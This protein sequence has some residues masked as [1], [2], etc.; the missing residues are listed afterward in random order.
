MKFL[1]QN[2]KFIYLLLIAF[3]FNYIK[4][5]V[6]TN[7]LTNVICPSKAVDGSAPGF[8]TISNITLS[9]TQTNN[10]RKSKTG[11]IILSS[12]TGWFFNTAAVPTLSYPAT[13]DIISMTIAMTNSTTITISFQTFTNTPV[14]VNVFTFSGIQVQAS[15]MLS[16]SGSIYCSAQTGFNPI[17]LVAGVPGTGASFAILSQYPYSQAGVNQIICGNSTTMA[18][19]NP[20]PGTGLWTLLGGT[21]TISTPS[22]NTSAITGIAVGTATLQ[23][24]DSN[25][26]GTTSQVVIT[27]TTIPTSAAGPDQSTCYPNTITMAANFPPYGSGTW[28]ILAGST[29]TSTSQLSSV[30]DESAIFTPTGVGTYTLQWTISLAGCT[31]STDN[32]VVTVTAG[33]NLSVAG[34]S[35]TVCLGSTATMAANTATT[36]ATATW[37]VI[38]GPSVLLSQFSSAISPTAVFTPAGGAGIYILSWAISKVGCTST[39]NMT[40]TVNSPPTVAAAGADQSV[41]I[42]GTLTANTPAVGTGSWTVISG[43]GT[44]SNSTDPFST[45]APTTQ[46]LANTIRWT[47]S[48]A[49]CASSFDDIVITA[50]CVPT[51]TYVLPTSGTTTVGLNTCPAT[52]VFID[53]GGVG[54]DYSSSVS[55]TVTFTAPVGSCLSYNFTSF[56]TESGYDYLTIINGPAAGSPTIGVYAGSTIPQSGQSTGNSITFNFVSD[57]IVTYPGWIANISCANACSGVPTA[58]TAVATPSVRC[59]TYTTN[60][61]VSGGS[62]SDCSIT[63]QW[64]SAAAVGGPFSN[65]AGATAQTSTASVAST[66]YFRCIT[67]CGGVPTNT[68]ASS[69][70]TASLQGGGCGC[71]ITVT[72]PFTSSG[73]TTCGQGNDVTSTNV[74]TVCG[75]SSYYGG[76]DVVYQFTPTSSGQITVDVTSTGSYMGLM[77][78]NGCPTAGGTC[79]TNAQSS[80]GN[81]NVCA[82]VTSGTTYYLVIDSWPSPTCNPYNISISA[83]TGTAVACNMAYTAASTTYS[84]ETITGTSLPTTDDVL[85][86]VAVNFGFPVCFDGTPYT[87]GY[88]ASNAAFVF[89]A[90]QCFPNIQSSTIASGGVGTGWSIT[91]PAPV[92]GTSIPR[93]AIL[94]P[95]HDIDPAL[96]G[97]IK[98]VT[99]GTAPNRRFIVSFENIPMFSCGTGAPTTYHSSQIK[100]FETTNTIEIH[101]KKKALCT[102]WN[103]GQAVLGLLNYNG[104]TYISPTGVAATYN[105]VA[106][107]GPYNQW[108]MSTTAYKFTTSCGSTGSCALLLPISL[109]SFYGERADK[110]NNLYWET[111]SEENISMFKVERSLDAIN[112]TEIGQVIAKNSPSKYHFED[113]NSAPGV[114][115]YYRIAVYENNLSHSYT[116][117]Y[118]IH[119]DNTEKLTVSRIYPNPTNSTFMIALDAKQKGEATINI[120]D[121]FGTLVKSSPCEVNGGINEFTVDINNLRQG[122]YFVEIA[123]SFN[124]TITKQKLIINK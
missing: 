101:I 33:P 84:F 86:D 70:A 17:G 10:F 23:W 3:C 94:A 51:T 102:T 21:A 121:V 80:S 41:C 77:L 63:Y 35:Q 119:P 71:P 40:L 99:L 122:I 31:S 113:K 37:S 85:F 118:A 9:E 60:L 115:N 64:Q 19:N 6:F 32:V 46:G 25:C 117:I 20:A 45:Y 52:K 109:K 8:S 12:P 53:N 98:Y 2:K 90:V 34:P 66:T 100:I 123:N 7:N 50:S 88:V 116:S 112:F 111:A 49:P 54:S 48:N 5:Q 24:S 44:F 89:D 105:A 65:I 76:E 56:S 120:Y 14:D 87:G 67:K 91:S 58:G 92:N 107:P 28:S 39:S 106:S 55:A 59:S 26:G 1:I 114:I 16:A 22:S 29:N 15:S 13:V 96:G 36:G 11:T 72:L 103:N 97:T 47:I 83:P 75:S 124:E 81:Q 18:A 74:T 104:T 69:V 108:T 68:I 27:R 62:S 82:A 38:S 57:V 30:N 73:Q 93:N 4:A 78:Y 61:S 95:W 43:G 42:T 110:I 79:L